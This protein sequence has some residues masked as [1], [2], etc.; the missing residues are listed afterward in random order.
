MKILGHGAVFILLYLLFMGPTYILPYLGSNSSVLNA[1]AAAADGPINPLTLVHLGSML[2]LVAL[3]WIRGTLV[4]RK[5]LLVFPI[6]AI[7]FDFLPFLN[8]IPLVPTVLHL[9]A[10]IM[11]VSA[12]PTPASA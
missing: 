12:R 10:M 8:L 4:N 9:L 1:T 5:W 11:G 7:A 3:T 6:L 2:V